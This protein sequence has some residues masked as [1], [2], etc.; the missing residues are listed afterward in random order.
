MK[1]YV[2][3][4]EQIRKAKPSRPVIV[5]QDE[6]GNQVEYNEFEFWVDGRP[7]GKVVF[8][9]DGLSACETHDVKAWVEMYDEVLV[10]AI[11]PCGP[12]AH[13]KEPNKQVVI[14]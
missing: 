3:M 1:K 7:V 9:P 11:E 2:F 10:I 4:N 12:V 14:D 13:P 8:N 6:H 5:C